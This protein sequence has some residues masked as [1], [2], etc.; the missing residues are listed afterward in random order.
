MA[1]R[2][3][4]PRVAGPRRRRARE[5]RAPEPMEFLVFEDNGGEYH[6]TIV[7]ADGATLARSGDFASYQDAER[8][9]QH[10]RDGGASAPWNT[11]PSTRGRSI[12]P[13]GVVPT[14]DAADAER[15]LHEDDSFSTEAVARGPAPH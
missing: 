4:N 12:S 2:M 7:A 5:V 6:W 9:A 1:T 13:P 8:S 3:N 15:G 10:V 14:G 11:A